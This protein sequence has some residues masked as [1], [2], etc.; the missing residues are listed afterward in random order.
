MKIIIAPAKKMRVDTD[1][2]A[3]HDMPQFLEYAEYLLEVMK[4]KSYDE[5]KKLWNCSDRIAKPNFENLERLNLRKNL[6]PA[7]MSYD[8]IAYRYMA[9][10]LFTYDEL[11]YVKNHLRILSGFYG[12]LRPFDGVVPYRLEMQAKLETEKGKTLYDFWG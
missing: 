7:L 12:I 8:G 2:F 10:D 5:L 4:S 9:P 11:D 6:T 3:C 1:S